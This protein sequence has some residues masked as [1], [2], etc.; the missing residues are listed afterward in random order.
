MQLLVSLC[1][2][3]YPG[4]VSWT[5]EGHRFAWHMMLRITKG[6]ATFYATTRRVAGPGR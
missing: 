2:F 3:S 1:H 5:Q 4:N 6:V